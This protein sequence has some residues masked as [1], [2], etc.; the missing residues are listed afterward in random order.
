MAI[1]NVGEVRML[2]HDNRDLGRTLSHYT[3]LS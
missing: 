3:Y 1:R 2:H